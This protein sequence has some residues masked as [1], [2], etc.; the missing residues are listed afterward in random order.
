[1]KAN[2]DIYAI[3]AYTRWDLRANW[4]LGGWPLQ[5]VGLGNQPARRGPGAELF[6]AGRQRRDCAAVH[7]SVTD[8]R[9]IGVTF[10]YRM[11]SN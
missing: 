2:L 10:N 3:P 8:E 5:R 9:R 6:P 7:G 1:M 11:A 4:S